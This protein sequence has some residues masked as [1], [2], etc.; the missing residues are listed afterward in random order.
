MPYKERLKR[1]NLHSLELRRLHTELTLCN[2][3]VF[4]LVDVGMN[5]FFVMSSMT[6]TIEVKV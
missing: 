6:N 3:I 2:K 5:N 1:L 4:G